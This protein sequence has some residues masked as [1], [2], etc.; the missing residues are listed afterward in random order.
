MR[1][2]Q[3]YS[4]EAIMS[5]E[6]QTELIFQGHTGNSNYIRNTETGIDLRETWRA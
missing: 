4:K 6:T 2:E 3:R 5:K 1:D